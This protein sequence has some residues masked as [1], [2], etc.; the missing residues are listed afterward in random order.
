MWSVSVYIP[1]MAKWS[2]FWEW[3]YGSRV[4]PLGAVHLLSSGIFMVLTLVGYILQGNL[5]PSLPF[6]SL[7]FTPS[8]HFPHSDT[9]SLLTSLPSLLLF[10][11]SLVLPPIPL[12]SPPPPS[13]PGVPEEVWCVWQT[14]P[15]SCPLQD[16][17]QQNRCWEGKGIRWWSS[18]GHSSTFT[19]GLSILWG[20]VCSC[21]VGIGWEWLHG[22]RQ[23]LS[24]TSTPTTLRWSWTIMSMQCIKK[25]CIYTYVCIFVLLLHIYII[26]LLSTTPVV[27]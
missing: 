5:L 21:S 17:F 18:E 12:P 10:H 3:A 13:A 23:Q 19:E 6:P 1:H 9:L 27:I 22:P 20:W 7:H 15:P 25:F 4:L 14:T 11:S 26:Y 8:I 16:C 24:R 2:A